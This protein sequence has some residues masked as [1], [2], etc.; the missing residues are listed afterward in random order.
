VAVVA[1]H[2]SAG[3]PSGSAAFLNRQPKFGSDFCL[4]SIAVAGDAHTYLYL[5]AAPGFQQL[6][7]HLR[8]LDDGVFVTSAG[9]EYTRTLGT[10]LIRIG[11]YPIDE[12]MRRLAT[13]VPHEN[14]QWLHYMAQNYLTQQQVLQGLGL[15]PE[16]SPSSLTFQGLD[17]EEFTLSIDAS[18][19]ARISLLETRS[20]RELRPSWPPGRAFS[21]CSP[22]TRNSPVPSK[23]K[24]A[25]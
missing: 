6:P 22:Q 5:N 1:L 2:Q 21:F 18:D 9:P 12:V 11:D 8:W 20:L 10:R 25:A 3:A 19:E 16:G 15:V 13:V 17:G 4:D 24:T 7:L 14:D 23:T